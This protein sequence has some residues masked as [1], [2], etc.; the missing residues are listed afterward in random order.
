M[1]LRQRNSRLPDLSGRGS[2]PK[3]S[4]SPRRASKRQ[5][6]AY[7]AAGTRPS[8]LCSTAESIPTLFKTSSVATPGAQ[9]CSSASRTSC[10]AM[11]S[12][13]DMERG[14]PCC[15]RGT[16]ILTQTRLRSPVG[17]SL[18]AKALGESQ[19]CRPVS[20]LREQARSHRDL[21]VA[22]NRLFSLRSGLCQSLS[23]E[24]G[25]HYVTTCNLFE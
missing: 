24:N 17:A 18:L 13:S 3:N 6:F 11:V 16:G 22:K 25:C 20:R 14:R 4:S 2:M 1:A 5:S 7:C 8:A 23:C 21:C 10:T 12:F 15:F 9:L 19:R